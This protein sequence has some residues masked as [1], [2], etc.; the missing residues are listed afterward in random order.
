MPSA[1][2]PRVKVIRRLQMTLPGWTRK[3]AERRPTPP[4]QHGQA[5]RSKRSEFGKRQEAKQCL[6]AHFCISETQ[7]RNY[8]SKATNSPGDT[9]QNLLALLESRLDNMVFRAGFAAT[10]PAA[11]QLV[12]HGHIRIKYKGHDELCIV[13]IASY[14]VSPSET[15]TLRDKSKAN[16]AVQASVANPAIEIPSYLTVDKAA[17]TAS[18]DSAPGGEHVPLKDLEIK[19]II[20]YYS[21]FV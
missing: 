2:K 5:R 3:S 17:L 6:R 18:V 4:G 10:I 14:H 19:L 20:E 16:T 9:G 13:N 7:L 12:N 8:F 11:R 1:K 21:R 15:I